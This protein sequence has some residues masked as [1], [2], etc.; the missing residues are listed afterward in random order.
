MALRRSSSLTGTDSQP[1]ARSWPRVAAAGWAPTCGVARGHGGSTYRR[2][3]TPSS[4]WIRPRLAA[5]PSAPSSDQPVAG[6]DTSLPDAEHV[7]RARRALHGAGLQPVPGDRRPEPGRSASGDDHGRA[8]SPTLG[9]SEDEIPRGARPTGQVQISGTVTA[10]HLEGAVLAPRTVP[11]PLTIN[12]DRGF[13]NGGEITGVDGRRRRPSSIVWDGGRPFEL[14]ARRRPRA[15]PGRRRSGRR[16][17]ACCV[18]GGGNHVVAPWPLRARHPGRRRAPRASPPHA[19]RC[20]SS[21]ATRALFEG[22]GDATCCSAPTRPTTASA[23]RAECTLEG[24][25]AD[26][27]GDG[28]GVRARSF[29]LGEGHFDLTFSPSDDEAAPGSS[30]ESRTS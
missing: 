26:H 13:G 4:P 17:P 27:V 7:D 20:R 30:P 1:D 23:A 28:S 15:R 9:T 29:D 18:L 25:P 8:G 2:G 12:S 14:T 5:G 19:T 10:I 21:P 6:A 11:A 22:R 16:R 24:A 3:P